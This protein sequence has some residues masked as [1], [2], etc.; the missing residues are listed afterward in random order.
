MNDFD[1]A[2][3]K[4]FFIDLSV[5]N[6]QNLQDDV[7]QLMMALT[8]SGIFKVFAI[9]K[10]RSIDLIY[11]KSLINIVPYGI[12]CAEVDSKLEYLI[13][14][15]F[16]SSH[17]NSSSN[18]LH[19]FRILNSEPWIKN[20]K[21]MEE[22]D[23]F[24]KK[25]NTKNHPK[26]NF[27]K[28]EYVT[29]MEISSDNQNLVVI[30]I[31]G[32]IKIFSLPTLRPLKEWFMTEQPGY[33]EMNPAVVESPYMLKKFKQ[34][35]HEPDYRVIDISWWNSK[36]LIMTR[37]TGSLSLVSVE[38]LNNLMGRDQQWLYPYPSIYRYLE[39]EFFILECHCVLSNQAPNFNSE[40]SICDDEHSDSN[41]NET[42]ELN[43]N[44]EDEDDDDEEEYN[45]WLS[46]LASG[47][48]SKAFN[49]IGINGFDQSKKKK[50]IF[51]R[52]FSILHIKSTT[53]E[54]LFERK[55]KFEEYG[56]ALKLA[57]TYNLDTDLVYKQ[58]WNSKPISK[59]TIND[60]LV[61]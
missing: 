28:I 59:S 10:N 51:K 14:G 50:K 4:L 8:Y 7:L 57:Q 27:T 29:K 6:C 41:L 30:Y 18:G 55:L 9:R 11:R 37:G 24:S 31:S 42:S 52:K 26:S 36:V 49:L 43:T 33:N 34:I 12:Y 20:I 25:L 46:Y 1:D 54:E 38:S 15:S 45:S 60:Y 44:T 19:I 39:N 17:K 13:L 40:N 32:R 23:S 48:K 22:I 56:E 3:C 21:I 5:M 53:P 2:I 61:K 16:T 35:Y 47:V 58:Q